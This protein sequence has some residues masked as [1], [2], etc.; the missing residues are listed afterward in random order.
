MGAMVLLGGFLYVQQRLH[1]VKREKRELERRLGQDLERLRSKQEI[2]RLRLTLDV[3]ELKLAYGAKARELQQ[4]L[5]THE[6]NRALA[7]REQ[8]LEHATALFEARRGMQAIRAPPSLTT[9]LSTEHQPA[10]K[11]LAVVETEDSSSEVQ[12]IIEP[13]VLC[14]PLPSGCSNHFFLSHCKSWCSL[15]NSS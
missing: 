15:R 14:A 3:R 13:K 1:A 11:E 6:A 7:M 10:A 9:A 2:D 8:A 12:P 5:R 4:Q